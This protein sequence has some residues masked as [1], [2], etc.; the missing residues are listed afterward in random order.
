LKEALAR[1]GSRNIHI[2][3]EPKEVKKSDQAPFNA[4]LSNDFWVRRKARKIPK[5]EKNVFYISNN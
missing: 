5:I 4:F 1:E 3:Y 2:Q